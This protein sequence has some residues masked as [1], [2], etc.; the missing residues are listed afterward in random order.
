MLR[1]LETAQ[2]LPMYGVHYFSVKVRMPL[3]LLVTV[4]YQCVYVSEGQERVSQVAGHR[5]G[6]SDAV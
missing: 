2:S 3:E 4:M 5:T 6:R 1:F